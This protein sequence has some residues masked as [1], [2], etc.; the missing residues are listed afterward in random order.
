MS[1]PKKILIVVTN[2]NQI[3]PEHPTGLW[4]EEFA[5][6]YHLFREQTYT[7][8]VAS[9]KGGLAPLDPRSIPKDEETKKYSD[10]LQAL[11]FTE[12]LSS[13]N[14]NEYDAVFLPGGHGT[15]YDLP[16]EEVGQ[17]VSKFINA[18]KVVAA[19]CHGPAAL[20]TAKNSDGTPIIKGKKVT[21]FTNEEEKE[22]Q[23][24]KLM[25]FL[26][27]SKL[28]ELGAEF[29]SSPKW[30]DNVVVDGNLITGQNPQSS[31][32][33]ANAVIKVL[34]NAKTPVG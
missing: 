30:S 19:V 23:L 8:T 26:L 7:I 3:D 20:T 14:I 31:A 9:P 21:G 6:P 27:E 11:Q 25:P 28:S 5:I 33:T 4:F 22:V 13:I 16:V 1:N 18:G 34:N 12:P 32:S 15:M 17:C 29:I 2:H 10:A 24:D